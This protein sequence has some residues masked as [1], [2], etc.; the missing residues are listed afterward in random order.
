MC[1]L[2]AASTDGISGSLFFKKKMQDLLRTASENE[3]V[4]QGSDILK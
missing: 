1:T 2:D 4:S 3:V